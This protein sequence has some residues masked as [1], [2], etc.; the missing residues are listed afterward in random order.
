MALVKVFVV[1]KQRCELQSKVIYLVVV[2]TGEIVT[3]GDK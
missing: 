1:I 3:D 2:V